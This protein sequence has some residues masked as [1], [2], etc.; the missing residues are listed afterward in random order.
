MNYEERLK[1]LKE[2]LDYANNMKTRAEAKLETLKAQE[3]NLLKE[4]ENYK[5]DRENLDEEIKKLENDIEKL[6]KE[7]DELM[8][9]DLL[10]KEN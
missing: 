8:P 5:V 2:D 9:K 10:K 4:L 1:N 3:K 7:A 6:F